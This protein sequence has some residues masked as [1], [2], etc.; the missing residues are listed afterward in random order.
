MEAI[1]RFT[2]LECERLQG[3]P[4]GWTS[5]GVFNGELKDLSDSRRYQL[6]GN[7][8]SVPVVRAVGE[9]IITSLK[10]Q[11]LD[12][13]LASPL[14]INLGEFDNDYVKLMASGLLL[15]LKLM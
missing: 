14:G 4:D 2:P 3:F 1:R 8:V 5:R 13:A 12:G 7:A 10:Y 15:R 6:L 11:S 9:N